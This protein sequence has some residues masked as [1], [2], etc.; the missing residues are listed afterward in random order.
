MAIFI[1]SVTKKANF[2][3]FVKRKDVGDNKEIE[4]ALANILPRDAKAGLDAPVMNQSNYDRDVLSTL[5]K[6]LD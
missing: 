6:L 5:K 3:K 4:D 1:N 2:R